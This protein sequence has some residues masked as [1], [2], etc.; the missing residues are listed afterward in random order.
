MSEEKNWEVGCRL[1][2]GARKGAGEGG[3]IE[4]KEEE[5]A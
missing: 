1:S 2:P 5:E 4:K 3:A